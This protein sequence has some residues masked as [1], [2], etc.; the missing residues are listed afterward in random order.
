MANGIDVAVVADP[1]KN[2]SL[3]QV[4]EFAV[5]ASTSSRDANLSLAILNLWVKRN[6]Y[7]TYSPLEV[8]AI[9]LEASAAPSAPKCPFSRQV[10]SK[11]TGIK[12]SCLA[13]VFCKCLSGLKIMRQS[14]I[15]GRMLDI[16]GNS[17]ELNPQISP[18][19]NNIS[20]MNRC[21]NRCEEKNSEYISIICQEQELKILN[22]TTLH[23]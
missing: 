20:Q 23:N 6:S 12:L 18:Q 14:N 13:P 22:A 3:F 2:S 11:Q 17:H 8:V 16:S 1:S 9:S 21:S 5:I 10:N 4:A 15:F 7:K 19:K